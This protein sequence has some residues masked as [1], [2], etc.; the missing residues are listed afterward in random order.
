[1]GRAVREW[2]GNHGGELILIA[3]AAVMTKV[4]DHLW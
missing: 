4:V 1:M 3:V 2:P